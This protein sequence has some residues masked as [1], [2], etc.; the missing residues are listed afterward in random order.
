MRS[1]LDLIKPF[2]LKVTGGTVPPKETE[3]N[4]L[5]NAVQIGILIVVIV[6]VIVASILIARACSNKNQPNNAGV[7]RIVAN[8]TAQPR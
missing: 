3:A 1:Y 4:R 2:L 6:L 5:K 8:E 7:E